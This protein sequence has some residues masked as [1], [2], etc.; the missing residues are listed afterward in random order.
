[1]FDTR[2]D[3]SMLVPLQ[4]DVEWTDTSSV[5]SDQPPGKPGVAA[6]LTAVQALNITPDQA[7]TLVSAWQPSSGLSVTQLSTA[8]QQAIAG[9]NTAG[10][11]RLLAPNGGRQPV[12]PNVNPTLPVI[13]GDQWRAFLLIQNNEAS[14]GATLLI[15]IDPIDTATPAYYLNFAPGGFG[16]LLD[17]NVLNNPIYAAWSGSAAAG[18][19]I[20]YGSAM[21]QPTTAA[22]APTSSPSAPA[23]VLT[24]PTLKGLG[25]LSPR[26]GF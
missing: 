6:A 25:S 11:G 2:H 1:M 24:R 20:F 15:S 19:V 17:Q 3:F 14:G 4:C 10:G 7:S 8:L 13:A 9:A 26:A 18:G 21:K 22:I 5:L 16:I 12:A 23:A